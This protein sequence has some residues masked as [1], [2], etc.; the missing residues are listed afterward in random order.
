MDVIKGPGKAPALSSSEV[1]GEFPIKPWEEGEKGSH[2]SRACPGVCHC[3][4]ML[5]QVSLVT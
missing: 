4:S 3:W 1:M 5:L 2:I